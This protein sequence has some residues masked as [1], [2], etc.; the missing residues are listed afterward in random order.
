M[1]TWLL[2]PP[3]GRGAKPGAAEEPERRGEATEPDAVHLLARWSYHDGVGPRSVA[4]SWPG[5]PVASCDVLG[6]LYRCD[7][8]TGQRAHRDAHTFLACD[9]GWAYADLGPRAYFPRGRA[10]PRNPVPREP[11]AWCL[12]SFR[13]KTL[14]AYDPATNGCEDIV[15]LPGHCQTVVWCACDAVDV[16]GPNE[17]RQ[18]RVTCVCTGG[19]AFV[20]AAT[21][22]HPD[23]DRTAPGGFYECSMPVG[24]DDPH[25]EAHP[26]Y[27]GAA[28]NR[29][30]R[31]VIDARKS[32]RQ[33]VHRATMKR[34]AAA[35][36]IFRMT[37]MRA[38]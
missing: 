12:V 10:P 16:W 32:R 20:W 24:R 29:V 3:V 1:A 18:L 37:S 9:G 31:A 17:P 35:R 23:G 21:A 2:D 38:Y 13:G 7:P 15:D 19:V 36:K 25:R 26:D 28:A 34:P 30:F 22:A 33:G 11:D 14:V 8:A 27:S 5:G 4:F 6:R